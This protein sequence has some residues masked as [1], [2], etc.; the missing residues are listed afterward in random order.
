MRRTRKSEVGSRNDRSGAAVKLQAVT[1]CI[2]YADFLE[3]VVANRRHFDRWVVVTCAEDGRTRELCARFGMECVVSAHLQPDGKDFHAVDAKWHVINEGLDALDHKGWALV[4]DADVLLPRHF[5]E[6]LAALPLEPGVLYGAAGRKVLDEREAFEQLRKCEPWTTLVARNSNIIGYFNLF[7]L[8][9]APNRYPARKPRDRGGSHDDYRF[10]V[11]FD[12]DH[13]QFLPMTVIHAGWPGVN[14]G[15]RKAP[16]YERGEPSTSNAQRST[17]NEEGAPG[18]F[19]QSLITDHQSPGSAAAMVGYFPGGR[20]REL[21]KRF[22]RVWL[23]DHF[24]VHAPSGH[25]LWEADRTVLRRL[26]AEETAGMTHLELLRAHSVQNLAK[27]PDGSL[28]LLYL[29]GEVA[30]DWLTTALRHWRPKLRDGALVCGDLYGLPH[31]PEATY[32]LSL[33][34]GAPDGVEADGFW[35]KRMRVEDWKLAAPEDRDADHSKQDGVVLANRSKETLEKLLLTLHSVSRHWAGPVAVYHWGDEDPSLTIA[36]GRLGV[37]LW[38][39]GE[40]P[41]DEDTAAWIEEVAAIQPFRRA[42]LLQPGMIA[43]RPLAAVFDG[44]AIIAE[45]TVEMPLLAEREA[46]PLGVRA[47]SA[48]RFSGEAGESPI[49]NCTVDSSGWTEAAWEVWSINEAEMAQAMAAEVRVAADA[50]VVTFV[51]EQSVGDFQRSSLTWKFPP[52]TPVLVVLAGLR[53]EDVWLP[54]VTPET[55]VVTL[56][57]KQWDDLP[58]LLGWLA[59]EVSTARVIFLP[60]GAT[61]RPGAELWAGE[62]WRKTTGVQDWPRAAR[63]EDNVTGNHFQ[64]ESFFGMIGRTRL[65]EAAGIALARKLASVDMSARGWV[66]ADSTAAHAAAASKSQS[67]P[68]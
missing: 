34:T 6:R 64:P 39:V 44:S 23:V 10:A 11:S 61:A 25:P 14:W 16:A 35:W 4:L 22:S 62:Q 63:E 9:A 20:W 55:R 66:L 53:A 18:G 8:E 32:S 38:N 68:E 37:E 5:R 46:A 48:A 59:R 42:L 50:T 24:Q 57:R 26:F 41:E 47:V 17:S 28:D 54:G 1:I 43:V 33:L 29:P 12:D 30:P 3:A 52:G 13:R 45:E 15:G 2:N 49:L 65:A 7:S 58:W 51:D 36:C 60:S 27:I 31:W 56:S 67:P 19:Y 40:E 21:A